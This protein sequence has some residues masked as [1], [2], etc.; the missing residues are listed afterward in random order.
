LLFTARYVQVKQAMEYSLNNNQ[1]SDNQTFIIKV[2][3]LLPYQTDWEDFEYSRGSFEHKG[4]YYE[5]VKQILKKDTLYVYCIENHSKNQLYADLDQ[6]IQHH[7]LDFAPN[8]GKNTPKVYFNFIKEYLPSH[9]IQL[10]IQEFYTIQPN[11]VP[12]AFDFSNLSLEIP[13]PPPKP[14]FI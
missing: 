7:L 4:R 11:F 8:T 1:I 13:L 3:V 5:K 2:P 6:H 12:F 9:L 14:T 10:P